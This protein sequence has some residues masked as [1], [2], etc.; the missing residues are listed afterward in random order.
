MPIVTTVKAE[1]VP[2]P[3]Y[4]PEGFRMKS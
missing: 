2:T 3:F 1:I 4:D